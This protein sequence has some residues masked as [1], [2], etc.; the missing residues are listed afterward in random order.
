MRNEFTKVDFCKR[1]KKD[2]EHW[3]IFLDFSGNQVFYYKICVSCKEDLG[4]GAKSQT[5]TMSIENWNKK[6]GES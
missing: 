2:T 5:D 1:C 3:F 4:N 6:G